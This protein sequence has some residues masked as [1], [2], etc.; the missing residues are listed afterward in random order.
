MPRCSTL[1]G[2][3]LA[4]AAGFVLYQAKQ[5]SQDLE[6]DVAR[7][8]AAVAQVRDATARLQA[9]WA[10]LTEGERLAGLAQRHAAALAPVRLDQVVSLAEL[11]QRLPPPLV[12]Q[13]SGAALLSSVPGLQRLVGR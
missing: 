9:E 11:G 3:L 1:V 13:L 4:L 10:V 6:R 7:T 12:R 2:F 5:V 8:F